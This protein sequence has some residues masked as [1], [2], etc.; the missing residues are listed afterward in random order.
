MAGLNSC[1]TAPGKT[2]M[3]TTYLT[4]TAA[5]T[6][7]SALELHRKTSACSSLSTTTDAKNSL[8]CLSLEPD[9]T[10]PS[11]TPRLS[12]KLS[13]VRSPE[14]RLAVRSSLTY[15]SLRG[16]WTVMVSLLNVN[17]ND[18]NLSL[19]SILNKFN[20]KQSSP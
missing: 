20:I 2:P 3:E 10:L 1:F 15:M 11:K 7:P 16:T 13:V 17:K 8:A 4:P 19:T 9:W 14:L 6:F 12:L 5:L 18:C